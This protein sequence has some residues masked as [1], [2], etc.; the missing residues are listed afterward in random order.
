M[1]IETIMDA[2]LLLQNFKFISVKL[3]YMVNAGEN[4]FT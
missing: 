4:N 3:F 2:F 1:F